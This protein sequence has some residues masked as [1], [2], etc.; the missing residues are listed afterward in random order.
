MLHKLELGISDSVYNW[1]VDYFNGCALSQHNVRWLGVNA[2]VNQ[3][4]GSG[5]GPATYVVTHSQ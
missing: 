2:E 3:R 5:V 4:S 1:F